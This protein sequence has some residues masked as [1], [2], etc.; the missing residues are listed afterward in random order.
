VEKGDD[1]RTG[2]YCPGTR[3]RIL[4]P[5]CA[6]DPCV[7]NQKYP[8]RLMICGHRPSPA[9]N[10]AI[11]IQCASYPARWLG[12]EPHLHVVSGILARPMN[13]ITILDQEC[14]LTVGYL[15]RNLQ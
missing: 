1:Q 12:R 9:G 14:R 4:A 13:P 6:V 5:N 11:A 3:V 7:E 2:E 15:P 10:H 8:F